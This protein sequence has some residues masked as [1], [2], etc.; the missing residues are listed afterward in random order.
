[1]TSREIAT[2][3]RRG[4]SD[5]ATTDPEIWQASAMKLR[6]L[7]A[8]LRDSLMVGSPLRTELSATVLEISAY[9]P[10]RRKAPR[11]H[12]D[13]VTRTIPA[14]RTQRWLSPPHMLPDEE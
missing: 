14:D 10:E 1:M 11:S 8:S 2:A 3:W 13:A 7:A 4:L 9:L 12:P 5:L 6:S